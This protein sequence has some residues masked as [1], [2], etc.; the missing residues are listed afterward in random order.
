MIDT[1]EKGLETIV[2]DYLREQ[3]GYREL[4]ANGPDG[5]PV[6]DPECGLV[7]CWLEEFLNSTQPEKVRASKCFAN[8]SE[9]RRFYTRLCEK[10]N[11]QGV[12]EMLRRGFKF[13]GE[14]FEL[15]YVT[16]SALNESA[17]RNYA[18]NIFGVVRQVR[19]SSR[20]QESVDVVL[21]LNGLPVATMEL[22]NHYTGQTVANAVR[23]Y[24]EDRDPNELLFRR[25]RCAVHF[26]VDDTDVMMCTAL[27]RDESWFM[28]FNRGVNGGKGNP[29]I[30]GKTMTS[31]LWEEVLAKESLSDILENY[32][33]TITETDRKTGRTREKSIWPRYHQLDA[34]RR[35]LAATAAMTQGR[36]F[37]VQHS[38]GSGKSNTIT[39]LAFQLA[40]MA[41]GDG[42]AVYDSVL[43]VTDRVNLDRQIRDNIRSFAQLDNVLGWAD[44]SG[45][46]KELLDDGKKII[47]S[48]IHKFGLILDEIGGA[49]KD[50]KFAILIDE[51][52]SSQAGEMANNL[53]RVVSGGGDG[54]EEEDVEDAIC[55]LIQS[56]KLAAN[57]NYYAFTATPK[58]KTL[59]LFGEKIDNGGEC[60]FEPF[61]EYSMKQAIEEGF[62]LDVVK[63]YTP[64]RSYYRIVSRAN[65]QK[66]FDKEEAPKRLR[67]YVEARPETIA[68]KAR[69]IVNHFCA[70]VCQKIGGR[71]R[72][73]VVTSS[74]QR[75][76]E[77]YKEISRLLEE[78]GGRYKAIV[79]FTDKTIDGVLH[80]ES[81]YNGFASAQIEDKF[82]EEP[83][84]ILVVADKYQTGYDQ[85]LLHTMYVD[86]VLC[87][88]KAVQTL[89]RLNR[90][91][92]RKH[93]TFVL[94]FAND[95]E[96][97]REA[98]QR[99]YTGTMQEGESDVN[100]LSD[101]IDEIESRR[102][103]TEEA[104][105]NSVAI[106][107]KGSDADR[108]RLDSIADFCVERFKTELDE[109]EKVNAKGAMKRYLRAYPFFASIMPYE[110]RDWEVHYL[111]YSKLFP[112]LPKIPKID[113]VNGLI[114]SVDFERYRLE[115]EEERAILLQSEEGKVKP[116]PVG[117]GV[118]KKDVE[119]DTLQNI[120]D[121]FNRQF[122]GIEWKDVDEV[123]R[124]VESLPARVMASDPG[125][126]ESIHANDEQTAQILFYNTLNSVVTTIGQ[127]KMEFM[128]NFFNNKQFQDFIAGWAYDA[129]KAKA[130]ETMELVH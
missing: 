55:R 90:C 23:Q 8:E 48:T 29:P 97:I 73:M 95:P 60:R 67:A 36:R 87:D 68:S 58:N 129:C 42:K 51:A 28:P 1:S 19:F 61:H 25:K 70:K 105:E 92:P 96:T 118:A 45:N 65:E 103:Y 85:P 53:A 33:Q 57:A 115:K 83:Y 66:L 46:L 3:N 7:K 94:D 130:K 10:L 47:I 59:E 99:F 125:I 77:Y 9:R 16:P 35:L 30:P 37:L 54:G 117:N 114:E 62:I 38:A 69:I 75:A 26:A 88:V 56:R 122:G 52:H 76:I 113:G 86:K 31:Y 74:I 84:R 91:C 34:T 100:K 124:Q 89:S 17:R 126:V 80:T 120:V 121:Q 18:Q 79:A 39:W 82:E 109:N 72:A 63:H 41:G 116:M 12:V 119:M 2:V 110:S 22:K 78:R 108:P 14:K 102:F 123:K 40:Q 32:A 24:R 104:M 112:K 81:M 101:L 71:A 21:F 44:S 5:R 98:F 6:Y 27:K 50:R 15:Y 128:I 107:L 111:F 64:Y 11:G 106:L 4:K 43:V 127:E 13:N 93:D 49:L 20:S